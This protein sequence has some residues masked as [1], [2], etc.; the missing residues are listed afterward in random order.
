MNPGDKFLEDGPGV[1]TKAF[2]CISFVIPGHFYWF[3]VRKCLSSVRG[4]R[5]SYKEVYV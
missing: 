5:G 3:Y 1:V 4:L 2:P